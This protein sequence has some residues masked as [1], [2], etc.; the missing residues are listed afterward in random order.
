M[1]CKVC[2]AYNEDYLEFCENCAA[3]LEPDAAAGGP[4]GLSSAGERQAEPS[5]WG[6]VRSPS[7]PKPDF[8]ANTVSAEDVPEAYLNRFEPRPASAAEPPKPDA[9]KQDA[10]KQDEPAQ[11]APVAAPASA[12]RF[13]ASDP[14]PLRRGAPV[15]GPADEQ[16]EEAEPVAP[17][18]RR[19]EPKP[20]KAES[21]P[22]YGYA[23]SR[24]RKSRIRKP[25]VYGVIAGVLVIVIVV[26]GISLLVRG[27][28]GGS[29]GGA[30]NSGAFLGG[31]FSKSNITRQATITEDS[32]DP[33]N[34]QYYITV[35]AKNGSRLRFTSGSLV[36]DD[37]SMII[38]EGKKTMI[39]SEDIFIPAE[40]VDGATVEVYPDIVVI[41]KDGTTEEKVEFETP[42]VI[43]LPNIGLTLTSP[44]SPLET[45]S[46]DV[47]VS[48]TVTDNTAS[49]FV[50]DKLLTVDE[51]G[52]FTGTYTVGAEGKSSIVVEARKNGY[53]IA[54]QTVDVTY[55]PNATTGGTGGETA[56]NLPA[57]SGTPSFDFAG[58]QSRRTTDTTLT[59]KGTVQSGAALSVSGVELSGQVTVNTDGTF[60]FT[61][62]M[63]EVSLY[64][65]TVTSNLNGTS[66]TRT[67]YLERSP[68]KETYIK[69]A[70]ILDYQ[71][72]MDS[73]RHK[74]AYEVVGKVTEIIQ[75]SP[76]VIA[77]LQTSSGDV[78][79][80]YY[81]GIATVEANDSKTYK[82]YGDPNGKDSELNIPIIYA[83]Y[84]L[85]N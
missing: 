84:I 21:F 43:N 9:F 19:A 14:S 42:I 82:V 63:P 73:P 40:P 71:Y 15:C 81:S 70:Y 4:A 72:L 10:P 38:T 85:K 64:V 48:G 56:Q 54:R 69:G 51:T 30:K 32:T 18:R 77:K 49:V 11:P 3:P 47:A 24:K 75:S 66:G 23:N 27:F 74:Q 22:D 41:G 20:P 59:V 17:V 46:P 80:Y 34:K 12:P 26:L 33:S 28:G 37:D 55:T 29:G 78:L 25:L 58:D 7:W 60:S 65:A 67:I 50:G 16:A 6:F 39:V 35:Y 76:F 62:K 57:S 53:Q 5:A 45:A 79:F 83:W 31:I 52:S 36:V 61:V 8:D 1:R 13:N 2:G 68:D 44:V